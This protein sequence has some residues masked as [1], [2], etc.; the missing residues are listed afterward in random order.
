VP[1]GCTW[2]SSSSTV[3]VAHLLQDLCLLHKPT[4]QSRLL[5]LGV[6]IATPSVAASVKDRAILKIRLAGRTSIAALL[7]SSTL[8][9]RLLHVT[10]RVRGQRCTVRSCTRLQHSGLYCHSCGCCSLVVVV[11]RY[12]V[13]RHDVAIL[14]ID[15]V[16]R[17][18]VLDQATGARVLAGAG[19][20]VVR[21]GG[22]FVWLI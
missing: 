10:D 20:F 17:T 9:I 14:K 6:R 7:C 1:A 5:R 21:I 8:A 4:D 2:C 22:G 12:W 18:W 19:A 15:H 3:R 16:W 13:V 11:G